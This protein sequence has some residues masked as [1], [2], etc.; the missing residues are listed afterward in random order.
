MKCILISSLVLIHLLLASPIGLAQTAS[1]IEYWQSVKNS[2]DVDMLNA[3]LQEYP[4]GKFKNLAEIKIKKLGGTVTSSQTNNAELKPSTASI[5]AN[6]KWCGRS[7]IA[8]EMSPQ[9]CLNG[10][11]I[12]VSSKEWADWI[13]NTYFGK[14]KNH[15]AFAVSDDSWGVAAYR[16]NPAV[17]KKL[18]LY[19]CNLRANKATTCLVVNLNG[20]YS[21]YSDFSKSSDPVFSAFGNL[22]E[23]DGRY[24]IILSSQADAGWEGF[25]NVDV[26]G[27]DIRGNVQ[28]CFSNHNCATFSI[29]TVHAK[30]RGRYFQATI[31][32]TKASGWAAQNIS[33]EW[34]L[35]VAFSSDAS[36]MK[37]RMGQYT[38]DGERYSRSN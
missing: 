1:E 24:K 15:K 4:D 28:M 9:D 17:A 10:N 18:A 27:S 11:G 20:S 7:G 35:F 22:S 33:K 32:K 26:V 29:K 25:L 34:E 38:F 37:G 8:S 23:I 30:A 6:K 36:S 13:V 5:M 3:Y 16:G 14:Y 2:N 31:I 19:D 21:E 12:P